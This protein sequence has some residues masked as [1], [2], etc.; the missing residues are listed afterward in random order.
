MFSC[1][2]GF[3]ISLKKDGLPNKGGVLCFR[4]Q[5]LFAQ[6]YEGVGMLLKERQI[7]CYGGS[8]FT[9]SRRRY[10]LLFLLLYT[11]ES[12]VWYSTFFTCSAWS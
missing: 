11:P 1:A 6:R 5:G 10:P 4:D 2:D 9:P 8:R 3:T 12:L 7:L